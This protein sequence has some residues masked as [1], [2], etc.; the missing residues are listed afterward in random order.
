MNNQIDFRVL[1]LLSS[2]LC[3]DL[4]GPVGAVNNGLELMAD[5]SFGMADDALKLATSSASQAAATLQFYRLAYG[6]AGS[7]MGSD[8]A[9]LN[10][11]AVNYLSH[12]KVDFKWPDLTAPE[13]L[14]D[15]GGK[16]LLNLIALGVEMLPRGGVITALSGNADT[17]AFVAVT[18]TGD[19]V[20]IREEV[21][22]ALTDDVETEEL[23]PRNVHAYFTRFLARQSGT[24]LLINSSVEGHVQLIVSF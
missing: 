7:R 2:R 5:D 19:S 17:G 15:N 13:G 24:D 8:Y 16:V 20:S 3:H 23:T 12:T 9:T 11:L 1:E 14:P 22:E 6:L 21:K 4:V 18:V 10:Q